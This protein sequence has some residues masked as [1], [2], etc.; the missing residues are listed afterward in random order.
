MLIWKLIFLISFLLIY[1]QSKAEKLDNIILQYNENNNN[2]IEITPEEIQ[3]ELLNDYESKTLKFSNIKDKSKNLLVHIFSIN[4]EIEI[5]ASENNITK[6][7]Y[8]NNDAFLIKINIEK[9]NSITIKPLKDSKNKNIKNKTCPLIINSIFEGVYELNV[10]EQNPSIFYF[11]DQL[12]N[13]SLNYNITDFT[14]DK[15]FVVF[16]FLFNEKA[17]LEINIDGIGTNQKR[18]ISNSHNVFLTEDSIKELE[19]L[20]NILKINLRLVNY[21]NPFLVYFR[22]I[23]NKFTPLILQ[24]NYLNHAFITSD[25]KYQHYFMEISKG[26]E[27]EIMLHDKRQNGKLIGKICNKTDI[28]CMEF[29][30]ETIANNYLYKEH[31]RKLNF[32]YEETDYCQGSCIL[33]ITYYHNA[34]GKINDTI[35]GFE[36]TLLARI[37]DKNDWSDTNI[38]TIPNDEYIFGYFDKDIINHHY[39]SISVSNETSSICVEISGSDIDI[40]YDEGKR[41]L[42]TY[43]SKITNKFNIDG[44]SMQNILV[45]KY[46][47]KYLSFTIRPADFLKHPT[48]FYYFRVFQLKEKDKLIIP[49][50]S[51]VESICTLPDKSTYKCYFLL[52][53]NYNEFKLTFS[54]FSNNAKIVYNYFNSN[55]SQILDIQDDSMNK[56]IVDELNNINNTNRRQNAIYSN[57]DNNLNFILI[58]ILLSGRRMTIQ[59]TFYERKEEIYPQ[60]YSPQIFKIEANTRINYTFLCNMNFNLIANWVHGEGEVENFGYVNLEMDVNY[61]GRPYSILISE[62]KDIII[63]KKPKD[64]VLYLGLKYNANK[65][66]IL[67][68]IRDYQISNIIQNKTFPFYYYIRTNLEENDSMDI[69][70]KILDFREMLK[71]ITIEQMFCDE[72]TL[73]SLKQGKNLKFETKNKG[74]YDISSKSG[75]IQIKNDGK[76]ENITLIKIDGPGDQSNQRIL[77]QI[78][79]LI[80]RQIEH[81]DSF[82][83]NSYV[84]VN[85]FIA[86]SIIKNKNSATYILNSNSEEITEKIIIEFS[87]NNPG[88]ELLLDNHIPDKNSSKVK[89]GIET[90]IIDR[91]NIVTVQFNESKTPENF[92]E[93]NYMFRYYYN[94]KKFLDYDY[95]FNKLYNITNK[96]DSE[97]DDI[98]RI[99]FNFENL[100]IINNNGS[101]IE[102]NIYL[103]LYSNE[104]SDEIFNTISFNSINPVAQNVVKSYSSEDNFTVDIDIDNTNLNNYKFIMQIKFYLISYSVNHKILTYSIPMDLTQCLKKELKNGTG[105]NKTNKLILILSIISGTLLIIVI[106]VVIYIIKMKNKNKDLKDKVLSISFTT[107]Q[108][109]SILSDNSNYCKKDEEYENT[110]I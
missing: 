84:P 21:T 19:K 93:G 38:V 98:V 48:T 95:E 11:N 97:Q 44:A 75:L 60:V 88:L 41:K 67:E 78:I 105:D 36:F 85:Q 108:S 96:S 87:K 83:A 68:E 29:E 102:Y 77:V 52:T 92:T 45:E 59:N 26:E 106:I 63:F 69:N 33:L 76:G 101:S 72:D 107:G 42:N 28:Q 91:T 55:K 14:K 90:F 64:F 13:I 34:F 110:F 23:S 22:V 3:T 37:W 16:Q 65:N 49:L 17:T 4:C 82:Y 99:S 50:D 94:T 31:I 12:T 40:F 15:S 53:N 61:M 2:I 79:A 20:D 89:D 71:N 66:I 43:N 9:N 18:I 5:N 51:N 73:N 1:T 39:Y 7:I 57:N 27:G 10:E 86:G 70:L 81:Y 104:N 80:I 54:L 24:K 74:H 25:L 32:T 35:I 56:V 58:G 6:N 30:N 100:R 62:I 103:S 46:K 47:G 8:E 109:D